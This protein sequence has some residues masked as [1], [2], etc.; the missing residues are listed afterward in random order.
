M[1]HPMKQTDRFEVM[2]LHLVRIEDLEGGDLTSR[3]LKGRIWSR[4]WTA[5]S[6]CVCLNDKRDKRYPVV[7]SRSKLNAFI[8]KSEK[9]LKWTYFKQYLL[10]FNFKALPIHGIWRPFWKKFEH[11]GDVLYSP[12]SDKWSRAESTRYDG[13]L[14]WT[15]LQHHVASPA[16]YPF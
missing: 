10:S 16:S 15:V 12:A 2:E 3:G 4:I 7:T 6:Y 14:L 8:H 11:N 5:R 13:F 9:G 1:V